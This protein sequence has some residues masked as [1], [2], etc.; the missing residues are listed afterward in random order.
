MLDAG[1]WDATMQQPCSLLFLVLG[2]VA[3]DSL[4]R[5]YWFHV[6][7]NGKVH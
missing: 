4:S 6:I 3:D 5:G 7:E 1:C 2:A